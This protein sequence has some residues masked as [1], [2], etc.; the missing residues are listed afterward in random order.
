MVQTHQADHTHFIRDA[1]SPML[2]T[3]EQTVVREER[4]TQFLNEQL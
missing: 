3:K 2:Q 1:M 4:S